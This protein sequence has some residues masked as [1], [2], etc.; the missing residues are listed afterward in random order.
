MQYGDVH[1]G[2]EGPIV[3]K[4]LIIQ[5]CQ[6]GHYATTQYLDIYVKSSH[7]NGYFFTNGKFGVTHYYGMDG[8][9]IILNQGKT[10]VCIVNADD[11]DEI[12][13]YGE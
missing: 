11:K 6:T 12:G 13:I 5:Y 9:E 4:N 7:Q 10:W 8:K 2:N 3:V 1:M